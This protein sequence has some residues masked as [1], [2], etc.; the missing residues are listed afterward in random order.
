MLTRIRLQALI[1]LA[2][3]ALLGYLAASGRFLS[4]P[5]AI[6]APV[7]GV[8]ETSQPGEAITITVRLQIGRAHV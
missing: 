6:A 1:I 8:Q 5:G 2:A 7:L 4:G 3:G